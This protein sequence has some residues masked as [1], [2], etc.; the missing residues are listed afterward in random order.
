MSVLTINDQP[1]CLLSYNHVLY[2]CMRINSSDAQST[3]HHKRANGT[4]YRQQLPSA[5][6]WTQHC[7][8]PTQVRPRSPNRLQFLFSY[9]SYIQIHLKHSIRYPVALSCQHARLIHDIAF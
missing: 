6:S 7:I 2:I 4:S 9:T 8:K 1:L 3:L 5:S